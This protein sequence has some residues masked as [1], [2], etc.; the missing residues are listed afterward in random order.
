M[1]GEYEA[2]VATQSRLLGDLSAEIA[3]GINQISQ[4]GA[5]H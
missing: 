4:E 2:L 3:A 5:N 1:G